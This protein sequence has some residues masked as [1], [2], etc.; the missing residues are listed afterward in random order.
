MG[1]L[2]GVLSSFCLHIYIHVIQISKDC[3][4]PADQHVHGHRS[5][6]S[7]R[8]GGETAGTDPGHSTTAT[9]Y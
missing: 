2:M 1:L 4:V 6:S 8:V 5:D 7:V 3:N 9:H